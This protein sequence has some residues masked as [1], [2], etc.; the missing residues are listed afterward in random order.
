MVPAF[1]FTNVNAGA[2]NCCALGNHCVPLV[3]H[4]VESVQHCEEDESLS[5]ILYSYSAM[6][7]HWYFNPVKSGSKF[8]KY[9]SL[10]I[11]LCSCVSKVV[12]WNA[13]CIV[14]ARWWLLTVL[15][16]ARLTF[17]FFKG[18]GCAF[19]TNSVVSQIPITDMCTECHLI[20]GS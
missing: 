13:G 3:N 15:H 18:I 2:R 10:A 14:P 7:F 17:Y 1:S 16:L 6:G 5:S 4:C 19:V 20:G 8:T 11:L 12:W 9:P